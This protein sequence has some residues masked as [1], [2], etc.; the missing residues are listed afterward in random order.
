MR[1]K[2]YCPAKLFL[3]L[4]WGTLPVCALSFFCLSILPF[5][6]SWFE[7]YAVAAIKGDGT[8]AGADEADFSQSVML[9]PDHKIREGD[10]IDYE[11]ILRNTGSKRPDYI[12]LWNRVEEPSAMLASAPELSYDVKKRELY[13]RGTVGPG[14]ERRFALKLV[15]LPQSAGTFI[16]NRASIVWGTWVTS[17]GSFWDT[18]R[19]DIQCDPLE[20]RS[21]EKN[22]KVLFTIAGIGL[23]WL[24]VLILGYFCFAPLFLI[25]APRLVRWRERRLIERSPNVSWRDQDR[26]G[27]M[28]YAMSIAFLVCLSVVLFFVS[29]VFEDIRKFS[30]Y[31]K[32]TCT[33]LDKKLSWSTGSLGKTKS[34]TYDPLVSVRYEA[35]GKEVVSAGSM[36]NGTFSGRESSAEKILAQYELGKLYP[37]WFDPEDPQEFVIKRGLYWGWYLLFL[38]PLILFGIATRYLLVRLRGP[39]T[40]REMLKGPIQ[41]G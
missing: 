30:S 41:P 36:I 12:E 39:H 5:I 25:V 34:R 14:E 17:N 8:L 2:H 26:G 3:K 15:T 28:V 18:K 1:I 31:S 22:T 11:I 13:W 23:G 29:F 24:E 10:A 16:S 4:F 37:C 20:V 6:D 40:A 32:S 27:F 19:K 33:I 38:G 21:K 7:Q 35:K 9:G